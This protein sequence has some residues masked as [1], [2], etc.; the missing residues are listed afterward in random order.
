MFAIFTHVMLRDTRSEPGLPAVRFQATAGCNQR[1]C[2][3]SHFGENLLSAAVSA[4]A[5][6][7][8]LKSLF[9]EGFLFEFAMKLPGN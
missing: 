9:A 2:A 4:P 7:I 1:T 8:C 5:R 6:A 3:V